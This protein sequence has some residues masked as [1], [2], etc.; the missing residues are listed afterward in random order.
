M[1]DNDYMNSRSQ[2]KKCW[3]QEFTKIETETA[4]ETFLKRRDSVKAAGSELIR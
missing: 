4:T 1:T 2:G 3:S